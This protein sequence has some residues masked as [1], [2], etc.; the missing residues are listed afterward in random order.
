MSKPNLSAATEREVSS[1]HTRN[2]VTWGGEFGGQTSFGKD[3]TP[4]LRMFDVG[5]GVV[6]RGPSGE[7]FI[8]MDN[9]LILLYA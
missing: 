1:V 3:K 4:R 5:N 6:L 9:I 2:A 8:P 7:A